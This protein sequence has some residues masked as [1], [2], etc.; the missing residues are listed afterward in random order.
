MSIRLSDWHS[1]G[2]TDLQLFRAGFAIRC[3]RGGERVARAAVSH[4]GQWRS[5]RGRGCGTYP[6]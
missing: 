1:P 3:G 6:N 5:R 2:Q 4:V